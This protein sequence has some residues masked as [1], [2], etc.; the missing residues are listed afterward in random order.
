MFDTLQ[1]TWR[2]GPKVCSTLLAML[3]LSACVPIQSAE[4]G[5]DSDDSGDSDEGAGSGTSSS[6]TVQDAGDSCNEVLT[7]I[8]SCPDDACATACYDG[9]SNGAREK[10][11]ALLVCLD[12]SMCADA[13]CAKMACAAELDTCTQ[14]VA[15]P[16]DD[17]PVTQGMVPAELV[18][19]WLGSRGSYHFD[20]S[21]AYWSVGILSSDGPCVSFE[22]IVFTDTGV[23]S[24]TGSNL[25][26][27]AQTRQQD[28][29]DCNGQMTTKMN[30]AQTT[31]YTWSIAG[32][33]LTLV[34]ESGAIEYAKM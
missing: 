8:S 15:V 9:G 6:G 23:A 29:Y 24:T 17:P 33:T 34:G 16:V 27:T 22:K 3:A 4:D 18:G 14:D 12:A 13:Q 1:G 5:D 28:T 2:I 11:D 21:G 26:L 10:M 20:E 19:D 32:E 31:Q 30:P 25:T 7:C